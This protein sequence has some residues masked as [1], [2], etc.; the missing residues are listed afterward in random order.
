MLSFL[1]VIWCV[2]ESSQK[3][4]IVTLR[5]QWTKHKWNKLTKSVAIVWY[6]RPGNNPTRYE[7]DLFTEN[8]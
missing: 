4:Q 5:V 8:C 1:I 2:F 7:Q 3:S 6:T